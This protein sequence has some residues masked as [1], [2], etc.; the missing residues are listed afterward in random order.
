[1]QLAG[2][3]REV[4]SSQPDRRFIPGFT[5]CG[6][7]MQLWVFNSSNPYS[8]GKFDIHKEQEQFTRVITGYVLMTD[9]ELGLNTFVKRRDGNNKHIAARDVRVDL[10]D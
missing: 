8:S 9:A 4:F 2:Y 6:S 7:V 10:G 3:A 5:I 1:M